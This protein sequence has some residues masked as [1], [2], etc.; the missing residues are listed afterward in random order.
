MCSSEEFAA[1]LHLYPTVEAVVEN[2]ISIDGEPIATI[3][4]GPNASKAS[5]DD[6]AGLEPVVCLAHIV[7]VILTANLGLSTELW[8]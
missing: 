2:N 6:A 3:H 8:E 7:R 1:A 5:P 4:R